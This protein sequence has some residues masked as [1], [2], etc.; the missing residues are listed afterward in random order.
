MYS[1]SLYGLNV[2]SEIELLSLVPSR[3]DM[4]ISIRVGKIENKPK[5][6]KH[7]FIANWST[8]KEVCISYKDVA[9]FLVKNGQ[10]I[11]IEPVGD[12]DLPAV[13][14][15]LLGIVVSVILYQRGFL[16]LHSSLIEIGGHAVG[17]MGDSGYGKSSL[18]VAL[19]EKGYDLIADDLAVIDFN[20]NDD[21]VVH[22][23]FPQFKLRNDTIESIGI[24]PNDLRQEST[25]YSKRTRVLTNRFTK[26]PQVPLKCLYILDVGSEIE[27]D[28]LRGHQS[29]IEL[30]GFTFDIRLIERTEGLKKHFTQCSKVVESVP[31]RRLKRPWS[32]DLMSDV[33]RAIEDDIL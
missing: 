24:N 14:Q 17:F 26:M 3:G 16:V 7:K 25:L 1:Y 19:Y 29:V 13:G 8:K 2:E 32:L 15:I 5:V 11:I 27:I 21:V 30:V 28:E 6:S 4:D 18:A 20:S 22:R 31:I 10:E 23:G 9:S 12:K 33:V